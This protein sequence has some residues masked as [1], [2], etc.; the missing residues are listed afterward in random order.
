MKDEELIGSFHGCYSA[1]N[2]IIPKTHFQRILYLTICILTLFQETM[3]FLSFMFFEFSVV[4]Y[5]E[6]F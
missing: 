2:L 6:I 5:Y 3:F 4:N 1:N